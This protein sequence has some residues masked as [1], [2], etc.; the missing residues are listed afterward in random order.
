VGEKPVYLFN[1]GD[2]SGEYLLN[3]WRALEEDKGERAL[4]RRALGPDEVSLTPAYVRLLFGLKAKGHHVNQK[5]LAII[6]GLV[7]HIER[8]T[9]ASLAAS[10]A[11]PKA[12]GSGA[13][14]SGLRF[15]KLLAVKDAEDLYQLMLRTIR[16][17]DKTASLYDL[18][19]SIYW[20][21]ERTRRE[22]AYDYYSRATDEK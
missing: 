7:S 11:E 18:A 3:W 5:K 14:V 4:L 6:A 12:G 16:M 8:E 1:D 10:M 20:W 13:R 2:G 15:R 19:K 22:W 17:L 9:D 21:N